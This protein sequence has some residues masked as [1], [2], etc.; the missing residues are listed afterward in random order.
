MASWAEL[1]LRRKACTAASLLFSARVKAATS[2]SASVRS[3]DS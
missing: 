3:T 1:T 2:G